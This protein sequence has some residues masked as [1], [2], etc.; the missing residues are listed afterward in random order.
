MSVI[1]CGQAHTWK[2]TKRCVWRILIFSCIFKFRFL[3]AFFHF[4]YF[5]IATNGIFKFRSYFKPSTYISREHILWLNENQDAKTNFPNFL[6][7]ILNVIDAKIKTEHWNSQMIKCHINKTSHTPTQRIS[8][9]MP[10]HN[11]AT[12]HFFDSKKMKK[13]SHNIQYV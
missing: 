12:A 2:T 6:D 1:G 8:F 7:A 9:I 3:L 11:N 10:Y 5:H 4:Q 13:K